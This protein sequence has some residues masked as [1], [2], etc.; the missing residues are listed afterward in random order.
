[1]TK[2]VHFSGRG[3]WCGRKNYPQKN[4]RTNPLQVTC[5]D[6]IQIIH[7]VMLAKQ[8]QLDS[9]PYDVHQ[10]MSFEELRRQLC[11]ELEVHRVGRGIAKAIKAARE[12]EVTA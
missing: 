1:M 8:G 7:H 10:G 9:S 4:S 3:I 2:I 12:K 6:C 11:H 5:P